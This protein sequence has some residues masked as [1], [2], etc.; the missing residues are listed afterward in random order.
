MR[1]A[2]RDLHIDMTVSNGKGRVKKM[3]V[4]LDLFQFRQDC[5]IDAFFSAI[6][7]F[8]M[9]VFSNQNV[10]WVALWQIPCWTQIF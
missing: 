5:F 1:L 10:S 3:V 4:A 9:G 7:G 8:G 2:I 6:V